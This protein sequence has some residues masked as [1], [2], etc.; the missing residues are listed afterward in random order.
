MGSGMNT[1]VGVGAHIAEVGTG[2]AKV[3]KRM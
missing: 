3:Q 2:V 1:K